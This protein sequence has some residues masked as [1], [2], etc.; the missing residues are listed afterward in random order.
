MP[1]VKFL[2]NQQVKL[3]HHSGEMT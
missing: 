3:A 1:L 2:Q